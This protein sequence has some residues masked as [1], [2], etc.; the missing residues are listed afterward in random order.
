MD[1]VFKVKRFDSI[2]FGV[3][4]FEFGRIEDFE[5]EGG[6]GNVSVG[7]IDDMEERM[8]DVELEREVL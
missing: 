8:K 1:D 2:F 3:G 6:E 7:V 5:K 4:V